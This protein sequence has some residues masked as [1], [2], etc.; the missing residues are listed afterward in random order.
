LTGANGSGKTSLLEAIYLATT[1]RSFRASRLDDCVRHGAD[2]FSVELETAGSPRRT[3]SAEWNRAGARE[4][5]LDGK[6]ARLAEQLAAHPL[7]VWTRAESELVAGGPSLRRRFFD[8]GLVLERPALVGHLGRYERALGEK[9]ALLAA[10]GG[11]TRQRAAWNELL[12]REGAAIAAA[13]AQFVARLDSRLAGAARDLAP[14]GLRYRPSPAASIEGETALLAALEQIAP[15]EIE[16][17]QPLVG[18]QRDEIEIEWNGVA[19]RRVASA[20]EQKAAGLLLLA[21]LA[22]ELA[23]GGREAPTLLL[24][25]V[26]TEL[27]PRR[28]E[29]LLTAFAAFPRLVASSNRPEVFE[30]VGGLER[31]PAGALAAGAGG[32]S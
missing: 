6:P 3:L 11:G 24:D 28:V 5:R 30:A 12:A 22:E 23:D 1:S 29:R 2:G 27:D 18:P 9:R 8:R 19:A 25:D 7:L 16:R 26:D 17:R 32:A 10:G 20:G 13:R 15:S 31:V 4:R 14:L 21:A